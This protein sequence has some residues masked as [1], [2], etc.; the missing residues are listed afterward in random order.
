MIKRITVFLRYMHLAVD[1]KL[2]ST[3]KFFSRKR[4]GKIISA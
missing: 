2:L 4:S 1:L 3:E